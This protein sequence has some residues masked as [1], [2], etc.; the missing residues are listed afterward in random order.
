M[1]KFLGLALLVIAAPLYAAITWEPVVY[2][3]NEIFPSL[4]LS[5]A[6]M[7]TE[8]LLAEWSEDLLGDENGM[9]GVTVL[10]LPKGAEVSVEIK[11][12]ALME[13]STFR[14]KV[15][16][17]SDEWLIFPFVSYKFDKL[18][19]VRQSIPLAITM[20]VTVNGKPQGEQTVTAQVHSLNDCLYAV[21]DDTEEDGGV[22]YS[23]LFA[24]YVNESHP[25]IDR[26]LREA[27]DANQITS[28]TGYQSGDRNEVLAQI[29]AIWD[30][31]EKKGFR[32]SDISTNDSD[33][34]TISSQHVRLFDDSIQAR[35]TNCADGSVL[36][37]SIL[38]KIG[39]NVSLAII[40]GHMF[41]AVDL[42]DE[43]KR[44]I[45]I[46]TT[47]MGGEPPAPAAEEAAAGW[48][49]GALGKKTR[50]AESDGTFDEAVSIGTAEYRKNRRK[51]AAEDEL[52]YQLIEI[53]TARRLGIRPLASRQPE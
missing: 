43:G 39:L 46:E 29:R 28:F 15:P 7:K 52:N 37:A 19:R 1:K 32:Y 47:V 13:R 23:W 17:D 18:L 27:L 5:T 33:S 41:L 9:I 45:G 49:G 3:E 4:V 12:N 36:L 38:R 40:P 24:A 11:A 53:A 34:E 2:P 14:G 30:V 51:F 20:S 48:L 21:M 25:G 31:L 50:P 10:G 42:D 8:D 26:I 6:T 44:V 35:Q 16:E 22:D